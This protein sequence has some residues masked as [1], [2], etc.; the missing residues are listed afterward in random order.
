VLDNTAAYFLR[1]TFDPLDFLSGALGTLAACFTVVLARNLVR[2][3]SLGMFMRSLFRS[4]ALS[5]VALFGMLA[6]IG[7]GGG[8]SG[9]ASSA[10]GEGSQ[11]YVSGNSSGTLLIFND[12]NNVSGS[13]T[14]QSRC[15]RWINHAECPA[16]YRGRYAAQSG[17]CGK[18]CE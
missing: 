14:P 8:T 9:D 7:S 16:W 1:G 4:F 18:L 17:L 10:A 13:A 15:C 11:L 12:A 2:I 6:I 3:S 5:G